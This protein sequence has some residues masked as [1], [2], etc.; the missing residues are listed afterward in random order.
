MRPL[1]ENQL[2]QINRLLRRAQARTEAKQFVIEGQHLLDVALEKTPASILHVAITEFAS[3]RFT[4]LL[5]RC[6]RERIPVFSI[7]QK[8][9]ERTSDTEE[10]QGVFALLRLPEAEEDA[11]GDFAIALD[12]VQDPGNVGTI[13]R[14]PAGVGVQ[15]V[16]LGEGTAT[17][18][19]PKSDGADE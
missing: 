3:S 12:A 1:T 8:L 11:S 7:S 16:A 5:D 2:K 13:I 10:S 15:S 14:T 19:S 17:V 9:A 4:G 18:Y 6:Q